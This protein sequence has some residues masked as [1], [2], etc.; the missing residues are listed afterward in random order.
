MQSATELL[1]SNIPA[2]CP[3]EFLREWI[4]ARGYR[5]FAVRVIRDAVSRTSP[6]F[7][8]LQLMDMS[9]LDEAART[10]GG[11]KLWTH[12][13]RVRL[14]IPMPFLVHSAAGI[15]AAG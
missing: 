8:Y 5:V 2:N 12:T 10:L 9:R 3:D 11:Q 15:K 4:E 14:V 6:S 13:L 7:A 1:V